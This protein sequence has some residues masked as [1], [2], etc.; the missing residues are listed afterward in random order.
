MRCDLTRFGAM[1]LHSTPGMVSNL[2]YYDTMRYDTNR[3]VN[4][5]A[6]QNT[7]PLFR[8]AG[9]YLLGPSVFDRIEMRP[10]SIETEVF[11]QMAASGELY[12][13]ELEGFWA[14]VG[15]PKDYLSGMGMKLNNIRQND[16]SVLATGP[17]FVGNVLVDPSAKIGSGCK[18][19]P[20]V[21]IG[22]NCVVEDGVRLVNTTLLP[23]SKVRSHAYVNRAIIGWHST[24]GEWARVEKM[25]VLGEDVNVK[26]EIYINGSSVLPHKSVK[27]SLETPQIMM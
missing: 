23:G 4:S 9:I 18:I 24:V 19:G 7:N 22:P 14:D 25:S 10:T 21:V 2:L 20:D 13:M 16:S 27:K 17:Q 11:P 6:V 15:Q 3:C 1:P 8:L 5:R 26:P 12:V